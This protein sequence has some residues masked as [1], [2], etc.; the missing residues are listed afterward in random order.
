[1]APCSRWRVGTVTAQDRKAQAVTGV[2]LASLGV[3]AAVADRDCVYRRISLVDGQC[4]WAHD[5]RPHGRGGSPTCPGATRQRPL[6]VAVIGGLIAGGAWRAS[7][8]STPVP[9]T[10]AGI[11]LPS[12]VSS[13]LAQRRALTSLRSIPAC[14][15][16]LRMASLERRVPAVLAAAQRLSRV[17][18]SFRPRF[19]AFRSLAS[20]CLEVRVLGL[21]SAPSVG[22]L[23]RALLALYL[24]WRVSTRS[25]GRFPAR[26]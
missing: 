18:S 12:A 4:A 3:Y 1:M 9:A 21:R 14:A 26:E 23:A 15:G 20:V 6:A 24:A 11:P 17:V 19:V 8:P 22:R 2:G 13:T 16:R 5:R 7:R 10:G 25:A